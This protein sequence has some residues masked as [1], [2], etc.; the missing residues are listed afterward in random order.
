MK[1]DSVDL[2]VV[3]PFYNECENVAPLY[4]RLRDALDPLGRRYELI[5]V[6]DGSNDGT[7]D[8]LRALAQ[9]VPAITVV[10]L[11]RNFGQTAA[12]AAGIDA[13][14]GDLLVTL[15][16]D[17]Q[18]DPAD[19]PRLIQ[20]MEEQECDLVTGWR[21]DRKDPFLTRILPSQLANAIIARTTR[22]PIHDFGCTLRCYRTSM[23]R[24]VHLYG[25]LHRLLPALL[26]NLGARIRELVVQ[27]HPRVW[28]HSKYGLTRTL[29]VLL[30]LMTLWFMG[31]YATKP[32]YLFGAMGLSCLIGGVVSGLVMVYEKIYHGLYMIHT[33]LLHLTAFLFILGVQF[34]MIG[35]LA[36]MLMRTYYESQNKKIYLV[37]KVYTSPATV[38]GEPQGQAL[39]G[40][41]ALSSGT[42]SPTA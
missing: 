11:R 17:L 9:Q 27:H 8:R 14:R 23:L 20:V 34:L 22:T 33:P 41:P 40:E 19:I 37:R 28:G 21:R 10:A 16:A 4:E 7:L 31:N 6:D 30:D 35:L 36:D 13:A 32:V 38:S 24:E 29:K 3:V 39:A 18:N 26:S 25:E 5:F 1:E 42:G 15:D 2:S 12:L